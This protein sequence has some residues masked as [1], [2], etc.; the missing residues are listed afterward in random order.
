MQVAR[1]AAGA[2]AFHEAVI[3]CN[4]GLKM[5]PEDAGVRARLYHNRGVANNGLGQ[6]ILAIGDCSMAHRLSPMLWQPLYHRYLAYDA[7]GATTDALKVSLVGLSYL[8]EQLIEFEGLIYVLYFTVLCAVSAVCC[9]YS[10]H[11]QRS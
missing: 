7:I 5:K 10:A 11:F 8:A 9:Y 2:G 6:P 3:L 1:A 4:E